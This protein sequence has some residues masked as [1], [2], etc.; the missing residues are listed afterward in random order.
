[1]RIALLSVFFQALCGVLTG[2]LY[3]QHRFLLPAFSVAVYNAGVIVGVLLLSSTLG[4]TAAALG[5]VLG[6]LGQLLLV[7]SGLR[8]FWRRF[9][10]RIDLHDPF[11]R[12][13]LVL[14]GP[15]AAGMLVTVVGYAID[16]NLASRLEAGSL[17]AMQYATTLLQFPVGMVGLAASY[18]IL[19]TLSRFAPGGQ[20][21]DPQRYRESLLFGMRLVLL[22]MLP[23]LAGLVALAKPTVAVLFERGAF[24]P[25]DT[26]LTA[27][28]FVAYAPQLPLTALDNLLIVAF[29]ARQD[30]RTPVLVGVA[31]TLLYLLVALSL[32]G[33]LQVV[34]LA[35]ADAAKNSAHALVLLF[36]LRR[37]IPDLHLGDALG[38]FLLRTMAAAILVGLTAWFAWPLLEPTG[39]LIGLSTAG[40][41]GAVLYAALLQ[42]FG[43]PEVRSAL[44]LVR[45]RLVR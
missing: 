35:L 3:A 16:R 17:S 9:R 45:Q 23:L 31:G 1:M 32:I 41:L 25:Q 21:E 27:A 2:V 42:A 29:Y 5:L 12:R 33:P 40:L 24:T 26:A 28:V 11:V 6:A 15:V 37:A 4:I 43:V 13:V 8:S 14:A 7:G 22:L 38:S 44:A 39:G 36:L 20:A 10:P 30:T 18:A 19:P 34:G